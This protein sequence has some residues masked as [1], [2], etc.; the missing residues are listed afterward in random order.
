MMIVFVNYII[1]FNSLKVGG[2]LY[3]VYMI[4][5]IIFN[6]VMLIKLKKSKGQDVH[7]FGIF[8]YNIEKCFIDEGMIN[9]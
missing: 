4:M 5:L 8:C 9:G 1:T 2:F 6:I 3:Q 7:I